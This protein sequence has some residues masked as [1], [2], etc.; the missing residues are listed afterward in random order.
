MHKTKSLVFIS[1]FS[2][3]ATVLPQA[4]DALATNSL[5]KGSGPAVYFYSGGQRYTFPNEAVY[6]TWYPDFSNVIRLSDRE[7]ENL[8][9]AG[10]VTV[11]PGSALVKLVSESKVYAVSRY[12]VLHWIT[13][14]QLA[15]NYYG[16]DWSKKV[17][18]LSDT[19]FRS[20]LIS[21]ALDKPG[22]YLALDEMSST[23]TPADNLRPAGFVPPAAPSKEYPVTG[24]MGELTLT[25]RF[26]EV[27]EGQGIKL[28]AEL[29]GNGFAPKNITIRASNSDAP[30]KTCTSS[31]VCEYSFVAPAPPYERIFTASAED[32][33]G[34]KFESLNDPQISVMAQS[35][36]IQLQISPLVNVTGQRVNVSSQYDSHLNI[37]AHR[38]MALVPG[39]DTPIS[40][41][42]CETSKFC[43]GSLPLYR[44]TK[45]FAVI[46][47]E[48]DLFISKPLTVIVQGGAIPKPTISLTRQ[49]GDVVQ[50]RVTVPKGETIGPTFVFEGRDPSTL[51]LAMCEEDCNLSIRLDKPT[52]LTAV[53]SVGGALELSDSLQVSPYEN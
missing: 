21:Y 4:A 32:L 33:A 49:I 29:K 38:I 26:S 41:L 1:L 52:E 23:V 37:T 34:R 18:A 25:T 31:E 15:Q 10:D 3:I 45:F 17:I 12:G 11:Q 40:W 16:Q 20:Y 44:T 43:S 53:A 48:D 47:L 22:L 27:I 46:D 5:I 30:L 36:D 19:A 42:D 35:P 9:Y 28:I 39:A 24:V 6:K 7:L 51:A 13:T 14:E 2:L 8:P 50:I